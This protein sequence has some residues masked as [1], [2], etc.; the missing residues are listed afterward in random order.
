MDRE[1]LWSFVVALFIGA[2]IGT[3]RTLRHRPEHGDFAGLR[4]FILLAQA[5][6]ITAWIGSHWD[7]VIVFVVGMGCT[8]L[9]LSTAYFVRSRNEPEP[10]GYTTEV[11]A[12]IVY[13]LGGAAVLGYAPFAVAMAVVTSGVLALKD[14]LHASVQ[15]LRPDELLAALRLLFASFVVLPVLPHDPVDPWGALVPYDLWLLVILIS[16]LSMAGYVAVRWTGSRRG[17]ILT[18]ALG[19]IVSSTA[20]TIS[21]ARRSREVPAMA[22]VLCAGIALSWAVMFVRV[23]V[24]VAVVFPTLLTRLAPPLTVVALALAVCAFAFAR[25]GAKESPSEDDALGA[26]RNPFQLRVA[27]QFAAIFAVVLLA[28]KFASLWLPPSGIY[29]L[30]V[31]SGTV[32]VDAITLSVAEMAERGEVTAEVATNAIVLASATNSAM[33][34]VYGMVLAHGGLRRRLLVPGALAIAGGVIA[35]LV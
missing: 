15:K 20:T 28:A 11:A 8:A 21:L 33:K 12:G 30:A 9:L 19:G 31:V 4:T 24:E 32:D 17:T 14:Q 2:L 7:A 29:V 5:G 13:L 25:R 6:A 16:G 22:S 35:L 18:G 23:A 26:L 27:I 10:P 1:Q 3:E 34:L